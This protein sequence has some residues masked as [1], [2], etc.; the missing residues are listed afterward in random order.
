MNF[1]KASQKIGLVVLIICLVL[2]ST[3]Q[4]DIYIKQKR[5]T[6]AFEV[7]GQ[8]QPAKD[9]VIVMW[10]GKDKNRVDQGQDT[11]TIIHMDKNIMYVIDHT[12][13]TYAEMPFGSIEDLLTSSMSESELSAEEMAEAKKFMKGMMTMMKPEVSVTETGETANMKGWNCTKYIM[14]IK[15]MG[16]T[17]TSEIWATE[18]IKIDYDL[19][20]NLSGMTLVK[21]PGFEQM[22]EE[23]KK[24]KGISVL[25]TSTATMMGAEV[26][27]TE[28]LEE[29]KKTKAPSGIY[30]PP[31]GYKKTN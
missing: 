8:T 26:K 16:A 20:R 25:T 23:M 3:L 11:S 14:K 5:H 12:K 13:R 6:D 9:E 10:M 21:Q 28:Q 27:S 17:A 18:D 19:Y 22:M 31:E 29:V 24:I 15:M 2:P 30:D 4:A 1:L 7:M